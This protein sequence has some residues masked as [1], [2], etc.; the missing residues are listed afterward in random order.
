V[1]FLTVEF[2]VLFA[3]TLRVLYTSFKR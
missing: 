1:V 3:H 2:R